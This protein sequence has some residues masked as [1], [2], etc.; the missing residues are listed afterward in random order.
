MAEA[1]EAALNELMVGFARSTLAREVQGRS[2]NLDTSSLKV[3][4][5][6]RFDVDG[7]G[8][9]E[10]CFAAGV[11][12]FFSQGVCGLIDPSRE[13]PRFVELVPYQEGFRDLVVT[14]VDGDGRPEIV[15]WGQVGSG[16][17]LNL[18]ILRYDGSA[19]KS[20]FPDG[21]FHQ[22]LLETKDLDL[23]GV[24]ELVIWEGR[25]QQGR[26]HWAPNPFTIHVYHATPGG[27]QLASSQQ[28]TASYYP[29]SIVSRTIG[30][31]GI[32]TTFEHR[33]TSVAERRHQFESLR[34]T[35]QIT[36]E[37]VGELG[38]QVALLR[39]EGFLDEA[40]SVLDI[41][42]EANQLLPSTPIA[43]Q[44]SVLFCRERAMTA[45]L[46][47]DY[48]AALEAYSQAIDR[49]DK[50]ALQG[51]PA[52][53]Q[54]MLHRELGS[55]EAFMGDYERAL[56]A[57]ATAFSL[58]ERLDT[59]DP[60]VR[61]EL[62]RLHSNAGL[63]RSWIGDEKPAIEHFRK[64]ID[65]DTELNSP[66]GRSIN[67]TGIANVHRQAGRVEEA[68]TWYE[69]ALRSLAE[70]SERDRESDANLEL[71][72]ALIETGQ[73]SSGLARVQTALLLT[74][75]GNLRQQDW[76]H[77][78][79]LGEAYRALHQF[80][81]AESSFRKANSV[82]ERSAT[83]E[84]RW[85]ALYGLG[86]VL[87]ELGRASEAKASLEQAIE[88][89]ERFRRQYLP[90]AL[91]ISMLA[92]KS[93]PYETLVDLLTRPDGQA[94]SQDWAARAFGY[95]E[96][97]KSRVFLER[98]AISP[99]RWPESASAELSRQEARL[100]DDLRALTLRESAT[101]N[102]ASVPEELDRLEEQLNHV[103][104]RIEASGHGGAEYV[105]LRRG[106][107]LTY[108]GILDLLREDR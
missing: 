40:L 16:A 14:D 37:Y 67:E 89:V 100:I 92:S 3:F 70:V 105:S 107:P 82:T 84:I 10:T 65:L 68:V 45:T 96:E 49:A 38:G 94:D 11:A 62:S 104:T 73:P 22:G 27:Y 44:R 2:L 13:G 86:L 95:V 72:L 23:D 102:E 36:E 108:N 103:W 57:H 90:E 35:G 60:Q 85:Q 47:G 25:W 7:D 76:K 24:D 12:E 52:Y 88:A 32:P 69:A 106:L 34:A 74:S 87:R 78:L 54:A 46:L 98:L 21:P 9:D 61:G 26:A 93:N 42:T 50:D 4:K 101:Q 55:A 58:L 59:S 91:K 30:L 64:A 18:A 43:R 1:D 6:V 80:G 53:Y 97:A 5:V 31:I 71:G 17:F 39:Q 56:V 33:Y 81:N 66:V 15:T 63:L 20:L 83:S 19:V 41:A 29:A 99:I 28:L 79:Y 48:P 51:L 77:Y 8:E 75:V